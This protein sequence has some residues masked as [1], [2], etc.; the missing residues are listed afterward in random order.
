MRRRSRGLATTATN[1][2]WKSLFL[3]WVERDLVLDRVGG[4][5]EQVR[6]GDHRTEGIREL[7]DGAGQTCGT[8][9]G[10]VGPAIRVRRY[11]SPW[12][13]R[14]RLAVGACPG[15]R[16][17][18]S[19]V[20]GGAGSGRRRP[21]MQY[22][23]AASRVPFPIPQSAS[24]VGACQRHSPGVVRQPVP[25]GFIASRRGRT[26]RLGG[27]CPTECGSHRAR[28]SRGG[29]PCHRACESVG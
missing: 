22:R 14:Y 17:W 4:A 28:P 8:R 2:S 6:V 23:D 9:R 15:G 10:G 16:N 3:V 11:S 24:A 27:P 1:W 7:G 13:M 18:P 20:V 26:G 21:R 19:G 29:S 12:L 25:A 5:A